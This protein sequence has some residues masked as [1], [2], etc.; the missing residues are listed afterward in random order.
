VNNSSTRSYWIRCA[1]DLKRDLRDDIVRWCDVLSHTRDPD[2]VAAIA[3]RT[4]REFVA[5]LPDV[6]FLGGQDNPLC[7]SLIESVRYLALYR[8]MR[9]VGTTDEDIGRILYDAVVTHPQ[10]YAVH[11]AP[12]RVLSQQQLMERRRERATRSQ[13]SQYAGDYVYELVA[14]DGSSFDFGYDFTACATLFLYHALGAGDVLPYYCFSDFPKCELSGLG[15]SRTMTLAEG[16]PRCDFRFKIGATSACR[17]PPP[18]LADS[19][20]GRVP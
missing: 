5:L 6:P 17:W 8:A 18:F 1:P 12:G 11:I 16:Y 13:Q 7:A 2:E 3:S 20:H 4:E 9:E 14:G 10:D 19:R 15:L